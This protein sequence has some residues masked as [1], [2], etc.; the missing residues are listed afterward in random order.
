[1]M[2]RGAGF[3]AD[4]ARWQLLKEYQHVTPLEL[5]ADDD[6]ASRIDAMNLKD[7]LRNVETECR[8]R[9]H[10]WLLR[11]VGALTAPT[12]VALTCRW[13]SRPQHQ[14]ETSCRVPGHGLHGRRC[15]AVAADSAAKI[16]N[17]KPG[18][19]AITVTMTSPMPYPP[20]AV[21]MARGTT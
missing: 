3:D 8:D 9:L 16:K 5:T 18:P 21:S 13:R 4:Q 2:R 7:R 10:V 20:D 11:I 15:I 6:I 19:L 12:Y 17:T 1:M 14:L